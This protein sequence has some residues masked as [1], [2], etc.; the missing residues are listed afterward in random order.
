MQCHSL[1]EVFKDIVNTTEEQRKDTPSSSSYLSYMSS[2]SKT[3]TK[4]E[5]QRKSVD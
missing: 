3:D 5:R 2:S 4:I 1:N